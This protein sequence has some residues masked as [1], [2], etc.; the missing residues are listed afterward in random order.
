MD[1]PFDYTAFKAQDDLHTAVR[2][3]A[4]TLRESSNAANT[5]NF[6]TRAGQE[7]PFADVLRTLHIDEEDEEEPTF[8]FG[9]E[10]VTMKEVE[11]M[12]LAHQPPRDFME[13]T[14]NRGTRIFYN[15][16]FDPEN[17]VWVE[18]SRPENSDAQNEF[19][20][21]LFLDV[22]GRLVDWTT[23][24]ANLKRLSKDRQY[25]EP[26]MHTCLLRIIN[27]YLP[28]QTLLLQPKM[29]NEIAQFLLKLD[30]NVDKMAHYREQLFSIQR[31]PGEDI[32]V[33]L[34]RL[35]ALVDKIYPAANA[36]NAVYRE[37][38][39]K[40]AIISLTPDK[41]AIPIMDQLKK[42]ASKCIPVPYKGLLKDVINAEKYAQVQIK[43]PLKFGRM[44]GAATASSHMQFNNMVHSFPFLQRKKLKDPYAEPVPESS[45][46]RQHPDF[47][48]EYSPPA[49]VGNI[50][51]EPEEAENPFGFGTPNPSNLTQPIYNLSLG[52]LHRSDSDDNSEK[53]DEPTI[54]AAP[55]SSS[56]TPNPAENFLTV[57]Y[58]DLNPN[59]QLIPAQNGLQYFINRATSIL[60]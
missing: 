36:E 44:I 19:S 20:E 4:T 49:N 56:Y 8:D 53:S 43:T 22:Q 5:R 58:K 26:M 50:N 51:Y 16:N 60:R 1:L 38:I 13:F 3:L 2:L 17:C 32:K 52:E 47:N 29:S 27:R 45:S 10:G 12:C 59:V 25:T 46:Y 39:Y 54:T 11:R 9:F 35:A 21:L 42:A 7:L 57:D 41:I 37:N 30:S 6:P 33:V 31:I 55:E 15:R 28:E 14:Q 24:L 34:N 18:M 48:F 40:T 23:S